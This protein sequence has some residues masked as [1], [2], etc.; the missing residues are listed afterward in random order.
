[1]SGLGAAQAVAIVTQIGAIGDAVGGSSFGAGPTAHVVLG[2]LSIVFLTV[3]ATVT[4]VVVSGATEVVLTGQVREIALRRLLGAP[5]AA[6]RRRVARTFLRLAGIGTAIGA[7]AG[8]ALSLAVIGIGIGTSAE[9]Q[10]TAASFV[11]SPLILLALGIQ[12]AVTRAAIRRGT[13]AVMQIAPVSALRAAADADRAVPLTLAVAPRASGGV[14]GAGL[15][16]LAFAIV[17]SRQTPLAMLP[18]VVGGVLT[19]IGVVSYGPRFVPPLVAVLASALPRR[20]SVTLA[21]RSLVRHPARTSRA[22]VG[23]AGT[24]AVVT[25]FVVGIASF[26]SAVSKHYEGSAVQGIAHDVLTVV[27]SV[28]GV[29]TV[30]LA[31]TAVVALGNAVSFNSHLRRRDIALMRILG[32]PDRQSRAVVMMQSVLLALSAGVL[33]LALGTA[34]GWIGAQSVFGVEARGHVVTPV[35]PLALLGGVTVATGVVAML[36][37]LRPL[38]AATSLPPIQAY[39]TT[40]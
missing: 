39:L 32:Q 7:V 36:A 6:E 22:V 35:V 19:F 40:R 15:G 30:F 20:L 23:V 31:L 28:I 2:I 17:A 14:L 8:Y 21:A 10:L 3:A 29:L 12:L 1:M 5:A 13:A 38:R 26:D 18:A 9:L 25:T 37:A 24:V 4:S 34:F 16:F 33:G 27:V 11:P